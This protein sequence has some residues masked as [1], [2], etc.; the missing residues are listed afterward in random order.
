MGEVP[1]TAADVHRGR[2]IW[3]LNRIEDCPDAF[4]R[5]K[6]LRN[7]RNDQRAGVEREGIFRRAEEL[8]TKAHHGGPVKPNE[9]DDN[10]SDDIN[11]ADMSPEKIAS[12]ITNGEHREGIATCR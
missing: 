2:R 1:H 4:I 12:D 11:H 9:D 3:D 5:L 10:A 8:R 6:F 7:M